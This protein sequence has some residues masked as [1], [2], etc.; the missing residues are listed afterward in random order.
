MATVDLVC[1]YD[2]V[3][4]WTTGSNISVEDGATAYLSAGSGSYANLYF[5]TNVATSLPA[6]AVISEAQLI[7]KVRTAASAASAL[8]YVKEPG[9]FP[10][11]GVA[12]H[13]INFN[14]STLT[15]FTST[16]MAAESPVVLDAGNWL[17]GYVRMIQTSGASRTF[18]VDYL[19][20]RL[21]YDIPAGGYDFQ[22]FNEAF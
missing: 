12:S 1:S 5:T 6:G 22:F 16:G 8:V 11:G 13:T 2:P 10:D 7:I 15:K 18:H 19:S 4:A 21:T 20:I 3:I 17:S 9:G 14:T